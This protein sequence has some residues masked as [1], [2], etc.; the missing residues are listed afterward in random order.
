LGDITVT[1]GLHV[2]K[3]AVC[4]CHMHGDGTCSSQLAK[5]WEKIKILKVIKSES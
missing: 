4:L 1:L 2:L 5:Q 3:H